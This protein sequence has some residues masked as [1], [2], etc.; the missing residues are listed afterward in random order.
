MKELMTNKPLV[1][2]TSASHGIGKGV[3]GIGDVRKQSN[4]L[5]L[6]VCDSI[7]GA[8]PRTARLDTPGLLHHVMM[9]GIERRDPMIC[10]VI[11]SGR[12]T[13]S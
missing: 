6:D 7:Y 9:R 11:L 1:V 4:N 10:M 5:S 13:I 12:A 3:V 2:I 8:M